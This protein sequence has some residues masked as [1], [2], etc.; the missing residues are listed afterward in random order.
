MP[1][2]DGDRVSKQFFLHSQICGRGQFINFLK[3]Q[4]FL[5]CIWCIHKF[6]HLYCYSINEHV[7]DHRTLRY[8]SPY[9]TLFPICSPV[10]FAVCFITMIMQRKT[11]K[12]M[13]Y[14][15]FEETAAVITNWLN[16]PSPTLRL[17]RT[18]I[19]PNESTSGPFYLSGRPSI[20]PPFSLFI[21]VSSQSLG[22]G[23]TAVLSA[24]LV[25]KCFWWR[26]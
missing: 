15:F 26:K 3:L 9:K 19:N 5:P 10:F 18:Y 23:L 13:Q 2:L 6:L 20:Y 14:A 12:L 22:I 1:V 17:F 24:F 11:L 25:K 7:L 8:L 21:H 4:I 16:A